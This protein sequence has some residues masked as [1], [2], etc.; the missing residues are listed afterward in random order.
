MMQGYQQ[1]G[2]IIEKIT[3]IFAFQ[4][5]LFSPEKLVARQL[6]SRNFDI[7]L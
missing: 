1:F 7:R 6:L 4:G 2:W 3:D 5:K